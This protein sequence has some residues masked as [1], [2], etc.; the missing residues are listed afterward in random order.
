MFLNR[1]FI[2]AQKYSQP[3]I[4]IKAAT[5][6][7]GRMCLANEASKWITS[8]LSR[9]HAHVLRAEND[10]VLVGVNTVL[11]DNPELTV[12]HVPGINPLRIVLDSRL[13]TPVD[14]K[15]IGTDGK[16]V[17]LA[18]FK[19]DKE[20]ETKLKDAGAD[21][22]RLPYY[23]SRIHLAEAMKRI[24]R[25]GILTLLVE[26]GSAVISAFMREGLADYLKMFIAPRIFGEGKGFNLKMNFEDVDHAYKLVNQKITL[27]GQDIMMEGLLTCSRD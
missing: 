21:I 24:L 22:I 7:D 16:C 17:I 27:L 1:G 8:S 19:A 15:V 25:K 11:A 3:F 14:A 2:Y 12:R 18:G 9:H 6:L 13:K 20:K 26:G 10:A 23:G 5:S 4:T